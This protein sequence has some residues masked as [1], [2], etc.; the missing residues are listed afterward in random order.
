MNRTSSWLL[1]L[2]L[3]FL[4][5][6][7]AQTPPPA[8]GTTAL[9]GDAL[10][11]QVA[12]LSHQAE[13]LLH[14]Q[15]E[16]VWRAWTTG[17]SVDLEAT[18]QGKDRLLSASAVQQVRQLRSLSGDPREQRALLHL[19]NYLA[20]EYLATR[21]SDVSDAVANLEGTLTFTMGGTEY[22]YPELDHL[23]ANEAD[24]GRRKQLYAAASS[25]IE[26]MGS[27]LEKKD[28]RLEEVVKEMGYPSY[29][30]FGVELR[31]TD[32]EK[33]AALAGKVL[34]TTQ[35]EYKSALGRLSQSELGVPF[36]QLHVSDLPRLFQHSNVD[37]AFP[38]DQMLAKTEATFAGMGLSFTRNP[39]IKLDT[40][41]SP[42]KD[43]QGITLPV[44]IPGDIRVSL[45]P[46]PG[47]ESQASYLHEAG[48]SVHDALATE[49][50]FE[51]AKLGNITV[52]E[53]FAL[54]FENLTQD[55]DWVRDQTTLQGERQSK[56]LA[57]SAAYHLYLVRRTAGRLLFEVQL[58][59]AAESGSTQ[60]PADLYSAVMGRTYALPMGPDDI[61]RY[62]V[63]REDFYSSADTFR[64]WFLSA[65][66]EAQLKGRFGATWWK[67]PEAGA[68]I[69]QL[70]APANAVTADELCAQWG[71]T[72][73][74]KPEVLLMRLGSA[75]LRR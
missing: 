19:Q 43:P 18:Y 62:H 66:L 17:Q 37:D 41:E 69:R 71:D 8:S 64:A 42:Q 36:D 33:L 15:D 51:L 31:E 24:A 47:M 73:G 48:H 2:S 22:P 30:A 56:Y 12:D 28:Q 7:A 72:M 57:V 74:I 4:A 21:M 1:L 55:A 38:K 16:L 9:Q 27:A 44:G 14:D 63:E 53:V 34:D 35:E 3:S 67:K 10:A 5:A 32:L 70:S 6:C 65:Q 46:E 54:V 45:K 59:K 40:K 75:P 60:N 39:S 61:A 50:R 20:G 68:F 11:A 58:H 23:L 29:E 26:R 52:P 49:R 13:S 25:S